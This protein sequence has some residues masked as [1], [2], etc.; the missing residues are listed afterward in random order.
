M[1]KGYLQTCETNKFCSCQCAMGADQLCQVCAE[2]RTPISVIGNYCVLFY[3]E[4]LCMMYEKNRYM[5]L[6]HNMGA[7]IIQHLKP[8]AITIRS[9]SFYSGIKSY[10]L[11]TSN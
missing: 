11:G 1:F 10:F 9:C 4:S 2:T 6:K 3:Y 7:K 8:M 5:H